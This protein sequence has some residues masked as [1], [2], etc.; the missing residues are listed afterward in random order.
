[1]SLTELA[2]EQVARPLRLRRNTAWI[3]AAFGLAMLLLGSIAWLARLDVIRTLA[4]VPA[5]WI[6]AALLA[7]AAA[8][9]RRRAAAGLATRS[10][11]EWL[12]R[13]GA[14]RLG[15]LRALLERTQQ[16]SSN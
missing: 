9:G 4:W 7:L 12:E 16:G 11:A 6:A 5:A 14:W 2:L 1:M 10:L 3:V 8:W 15:S 13:S